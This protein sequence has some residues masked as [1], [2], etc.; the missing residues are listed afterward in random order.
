MLRARVEFGH[1]QNSEPASDTFNPDFDFSD[2]FE[3]NGTY[4]LERVYCK[5][6]SKR[7][8]I[9]IDLASPNIK[10]RSLKA[11]IDLGT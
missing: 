11:I 8:L 2:E 7:S 6:R 4:V 10:K 5:Q 9:F 1:D 3:A